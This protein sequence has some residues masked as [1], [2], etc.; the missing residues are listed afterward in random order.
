MI[1]VLIIG[2]VFVSLYLGIS[3]GFGVTQ[4][5]REDVRAT[6]IMLQRMEGIRLFT[7]DQLTNTA[8]NPPTF[9]ER[10]YPGTG[11]GT[12]RGVTYTGTVAVTDITLT[13]TATYADRMKQVTVT[14]QWVSG[15]VPRTRSLTTYAAKNGIQ[16]Y[17]Y[18]N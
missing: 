7:W 13:P 6:Q 5:E 11:N 10:F 2:I 1:A 9:Q 15:R 4:L 17:I 14:V 16:R 8:L 18:N 12:A 3:F